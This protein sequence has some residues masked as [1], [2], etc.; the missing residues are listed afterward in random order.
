MRSYHT[1]LPSTGSSTVPHGQFAEINSDTMGALY[2]DVLVTP[3]TTMYWSLNHS[4]RHGDDTM[5]VFIVDPRKFD[6]EQAKGGTIYEDMDGSLGLQATITSPSD[7]KDGV[8]GNWTYYN[9]MDEENSGPYVVAEDQY[10]ARFYFLSSSTTSAK[11]CEDQTAYDFN[12]VKKTCKESN[13]QLSDTTGTAIAGNLIDNVVFSKKAPVGLMIE[14]SVSGA[15]EQQ[16]SRIPAG[17][18]K[19]V[20]TNSAGVEVGTVTLPTLNGGWSNGITQLPID[21]YTVTEVINDS[22]KSAVYPA[23]YNGTTVDGT[24]G[25]STEVTLEAD[26]STT[27]RFVNIY[28]PSGSVSTQKT[29]SGT[30]T[31]NMYLTLDAF[32][33]GAV[34]T[35]S[36]DKPADIVL[37]LDQS[38]SMLIPMGHDYYHYSGTKFEPS[39]NVQSYTYEQ[40]LNSAEL[41][42]KAYKTGYFMTQSEDNNWFVVSRDENGWSYHIVSDCGLGVDYCNRWEKWSPTGNIVN[43]RPEYIKDGNLSDTVLYGTATMNNMDYTV[44]SL[45]A[46]H[47]QLRGTYYVTQYGALYDALNEFVSSVKTSGVAHRIAFVGFAGDSLYYDSGDIFAET[48]DGVPISKRSMGSGVY[49][50]SN[51]NLYSSPTAVG[52]GPASSVYGKA[53]VDI[54]TDAGY[55]SILNSVNAYETNGAGTN[56][57]LGLHMANGIL[58]DNPLPEG[59]DR[60]R[61]VIFFTDGEAS[62]KMDSND[63]TAGQGSAINYAKTTKD[64]GA[65]LYAI[66]TST[67]TNYDSLNYISSNYPDATYPYESGA[68]TGTKVQFT[69]TPTDGY[70]KMITT[71]DELKNIFNSLSVEVTQTTANLSETAILRDVISE[72]FQLDVSDERPINVKLAAYNGSDFA[73]E[74]SLLIDGATHD[75]SCEHCNNI[76]YQVGTM[77]DGVFTADADQSK[78]IGNVIQVTGFDY[79]AHYVTTGVPDGYKIVVEIPIK[80]ADS[81]KGGTH[82]ATNDDEKTGIYDGDEKVVDCPEPYADVPYQVT[83]KKIV[84]LP[85]GGTTTQEFPFEATYKTLTTYG[86]TELTTGNDSNQL[87]FDATVTNA[88]PVAVV[89]DAKWSQSLGHEGEGI[90]TGIIPAPETVPEGADYSLTITEGDHPGYHMSVQ[91][92][93]LKDDS[94]YEAAIK[95]TD[96]TVTE[97][98]VVITNIQPGMRVTFTNSTGAVLPST[99]GMGTTVFYIVGAVLM[100]GAVVF[101]VARK[102]MGKEE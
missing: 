9:C 53:L 4:G 11:Y 32:A 12:G 64:Y 60:D 3:G 89:A 56:W 93:Y 98:G 17:T 34:T 30:D 77:Q 95:G 101:L 55:A 88:T 48:I 85:N 90:I 10:V 80:P 7:S 44:G 47:E 63:A 20:I 38:S 65:K 8:Y 102:K 67:T 58:A 43:G 62:G 86:N 24:A 46:V 22:V 49:I 87:T 54:S 96:Y 83:V 70:F 5:Q 57:A 69:T 71:A 45:D 72:N 40:L 2:Q 75:A 35:V 33:E 76:Q 6:A 39:G 79:S 66:A 52:G 18:Y 78:P 50:G 25:V 21:T 29:V 41:Q 73:D 19:F 37:V 14:K 94:S 16:L 23:T 28:N 82:Q 91:V 74:E 99:G 59:E 68:Y 81:N 51:F 27:V 36:K 92:E 100:L 13:D 15:N 97:N 1:K 42:S 26:I 31:T 84:Q 61:F